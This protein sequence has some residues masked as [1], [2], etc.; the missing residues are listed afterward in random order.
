VPSLEDVFLYLLD[1][2]GARAGEG[3]RA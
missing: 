2:Q 1:S 3:A